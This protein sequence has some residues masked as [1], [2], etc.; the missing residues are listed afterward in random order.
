MLQHKVLRINDT[1]F[2]DSL[3]S[4]LNHGWK[5]SGDVEGCIILSKEFKAV[6]TKHSCAEWDGLEV[7]FRSSEWET[8]SC[9]EPSMYKA[10]PKL[11]DIGFDIH[12]ECGRLGVDVKDFEYILEK[13]KEQRK[14][15]LD[16]LESRA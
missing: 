10:F 14:L 1:M 13:Y 6:Y 7:D 4:Y 12:N 11:D 2:T 16:L 5:V 3:E 15:L 8:C 9:F